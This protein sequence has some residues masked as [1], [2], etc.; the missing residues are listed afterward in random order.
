ML[1]SSINLIKYWYRMAI[2]LLRAVFLAQQTG[3][4]RSL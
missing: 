4:E 3:K 1:T 2:D